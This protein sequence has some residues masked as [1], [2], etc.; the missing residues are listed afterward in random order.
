MQKNTARFGTLEYREEDV[1]SITGG[2]IGFGYLTSF[3]L[4]QHKPE[5][6]FQWLQSLDDGDTAFLVADPCALVPGYAPAISDHEASEL[7]L[8]ENAP[9]FLL[10]TVSIPQSRPQDLT[11]NLAAPIVVN[12][13]S[14]IG[15]QVVLEG[16]AYTIKHRVFPTADEEG[17]AIA[18]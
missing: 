11:I 15:K 12:A 3:V 2:L 13:T 17:E 1:V 4:V 6:P 14:K 8:V 16:D 5:S 9:V 10:S 18:A 7:G